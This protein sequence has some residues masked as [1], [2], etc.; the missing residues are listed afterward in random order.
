MSALIC[1]R[2][3]HIRH[4]IVEVAAHM[5]KAPFREG[6]TFLEGLAMLSDAVYC[7][8]VYGADQPPLGYACDFD[9]VLDPLF[10]PLFVVAPRQMGEE[11]TFPRATRPSPRI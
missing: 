5:W 7:L 6:L 2:R 9:K 3:Y 10:G 1:W 4:F 11:M 8:D